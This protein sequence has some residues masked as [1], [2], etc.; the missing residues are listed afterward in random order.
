MLV[1]KNSIRWKIL[2]MNF[3]EVILL[4]LLLCLLCLM[5]MVGLP[6]LIVNNQRRRQ[7]AIAGILPTLE[8]AG[9]RLRPAWRFLLDRNLSLLETP[10]GKWR[11]FLEELKRN[12][13]DKEFSKFLVFQ[14][15]QLHWRGFFIASPNFADRI[16]NFLY[17]TDWPRQELDA[18]RPLGLVAICNKEHAA[19]MQAILSR[20]QAQAIF[21]SLV[22]DGDVFYIFSDSDEFLKLSL[23]LTPSSARH[24][25]N[26]LRFWNQF[27]ELV[28]RPGDLRNL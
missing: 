11:I 2:R 9:F 12:E 15:E 21:E 7:E 20:P 25:Q 26:W 10:D 1:K 4:N 14:A 13:Q 16:G 18:F 27:L 22:R 24:V 19:R 17:D 8:S 5:P 23:A 28:R 3:S 6:L